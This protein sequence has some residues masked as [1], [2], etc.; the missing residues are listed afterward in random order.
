MKVGLSKEW[1]RRPRIRII[2]LGSR[3]WGR[4]WLV[5]SINN[6]A[7]ATNQIITQKKAPRTELS[8][9]RYHYA[10]HEVGHKIGFLAV[11]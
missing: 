11:L 6:G 7:V 3:I 8:S 5:T 1:T 2:G 10:D 4:G 9:K